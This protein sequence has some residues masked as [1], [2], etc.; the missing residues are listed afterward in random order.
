MCS[1]VI[2]ILAQNL[3]NATNKHVK[4][5]VQTQRCHFIRNKETIWSVGNA[6]VALFSIH[7]RLVD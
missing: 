2:N 4:K 6:L 3:K 1:E 7:H 5:S